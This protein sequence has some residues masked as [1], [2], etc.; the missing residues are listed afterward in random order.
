VAAIAQGDQ[1]FLRIIAKSASPLNVVNFKIAQRPTSLAAPS[2]ALQHSLSQSWIRFPIE[3]KARPVL[4]NGN[5]QFSFL[6]RKS[7]DEQLAKRSRSSTFHEFA[8]LPACWHRWQ[9]LHKVIRF[10]SAS[11]PRELR[12][13]RW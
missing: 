13:R 9:Q 6:A 10:S 12:D 11:S 2:V 7:L 1:V 3:S 4:P 8:Y 5:G